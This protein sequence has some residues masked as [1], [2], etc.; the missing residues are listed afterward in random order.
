LLPRTVNEDIAGDVERCTA[1]IVG[2]TECSAD[3]I[4]ISTNGG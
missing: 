3:D 1:G 2:A 4:Q